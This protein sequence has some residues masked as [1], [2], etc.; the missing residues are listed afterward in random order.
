MGRGRGIGLLVLSAFIV[1]FSLVTA[2]AQGQAT[3]GSQQKGQLGVEVKDLTKEEADNL[4]LPPGRGVRVVRI[5]EGGPAAAAGV[6]PDDVLLSL[7]GSD[8][9]GVKDFVAAIQT[10]SPGAQVLLRASRG[11]AERTM[12]AVLALTRSAVESTPR[13]ML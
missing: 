1:L 3:A 9:T 2:R 8:I 13:L 12:V 10:R 11:G 5:I 4:G 6:A 7:D